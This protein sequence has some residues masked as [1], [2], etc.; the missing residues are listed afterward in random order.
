MAKNKAL[1]DFY[2]NLSDVCLK[3]I[4]LY[5]VK[6]NGQSALSCNCG[7]SI[8]EFL[9]VWS[10]NIFYGVIFIFVLNK[11]TELEPYI[12]FFFNGN[13]AF[14]PTRCVFVNATY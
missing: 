14:F 5:S 3:H 11:K 7:L 2:C 9:W 12:S 4:R 1:A 6:T 8:N 13:R 10:R